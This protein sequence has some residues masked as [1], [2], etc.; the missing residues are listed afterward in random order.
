ME[1][2]GQ[3]QQEIMEREQTI[4]Q[5]IQS[6]GQLKSKLEFLLDDH[7]KLQNAL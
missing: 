7:N 2:K 6:E 5:L 1:L 4:Q 3:M